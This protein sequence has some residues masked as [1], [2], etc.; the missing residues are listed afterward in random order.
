MTRFRNQ[1]RPLR[2]TAGL[3][4][5]V[6]LTVAIVLGGPLSAVAASESPDGVT[7]LTG[8]TIALDPH[9]VSLLPETYIA[10]LDLTAFV[11]RD[12]NLPLPP[13]PQIMT[14]LSGDWLSGA[15]Y[16]LPLPIAPRGQLNDVG[17]GRGGAGV[18]IYSL[19]FRAN[20]IG[21]PF[22]GP[23][24]H[25]GWSRVST[26]LAATQDTGEVVGGR[27]VVWA[28]DDDQFF[29]TGFG[30]DDRLFT[31]DDPV[32]PISAGWTVVDLDQR[33]F[34]HLRDAA[35]EVP[36]REIDAG[37]EDLSGLSYTEAFDE[38]IKHLRLRY[39]FTAYKG[40]DWDA[41]VAEIRPRIE[42]AE[43]TRNPG[44]F[45]LAML[46]F[47]VL[48]RDGHV[49]V[50]PP[51]E[52]LLAN[53]GGGI[54]VE[55]GVT[56]DR[57]ITLRCVAPD[58]PAAQA[59]LQPAAEIL[60]WNG[61]DPLAVLARTPQIFSASTDFNAELA[62][63][64][65]MARMKPGKEIAVTYRNPGSA[66]T[67]SAKLV[68]VE[69]LEGLGPN[70]CGEEVI[71]LSELPVTVDVLPSGIGYIKVNTFI[72]DVTL[73]T[74]AWEWAIQRLNALEVPA[75]IV[76]VRLNQGGFI[77]L[78]TYFAGSFTDEPFVL[79]TGFLSDESGNQIDVGDLRV[80][81]APAQWTKPVAVIINPGCA[82]A[83]E[84]FAAAV[85]HDPE[86]LIVGRSSSAGV[87]AGVAVWLLPGG[88]S[89]QAPVIAFRNP[90][91]TVF[92][93]GVGVVPNVKVP[94]TPETLLVNPRD[95]AA[96]DAAV[97]ALQALVA[98]P[99]ETTSTAP[100]S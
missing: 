39:P 36:I 16:A 92:L 40:L 14:G 68:A 15:A 61:E 67:R 81:P 33:P 86:N 89:F 34:A 75:V 65:L 26:S 35:V 56:D 43:R 9:F 84:I 98:E 63:L 28:P 97:D 25:K 57:R 48:M 42:Q 21:D 44:A 24:E 58:L 99:A 83:C 76:D 2:W 45:N 37:F 10:L 96:L 18:Q 32:G 60:S 100:T 7:T 73:M 88:L 93:E 38:L 51:E 12:P 41:I 77:S 62:R 23:F 50:A 53:Y 79:N 74:R 91:G 71:D 78:A 82:S 49:A 5:L 66:A 90:D 47:S 87:E 54:G 3:R 20:F 29:P 13:A 27:I 55:L 59:G 11:E 64:V 72:D 94:N 22:L 70:P 52:W 46:Q 85:A 8:T 1:L 80:E 6:A 69:D 4:L 30:S 17:H 19:E 31:A 95:D